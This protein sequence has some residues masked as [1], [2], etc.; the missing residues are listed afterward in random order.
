M[1]FID[2]H[3]QAHDAGM[4]AAAPAQGDTIRL[5]D[6]KQTYI[7]DD[8]PCGFAWVW[9]KGNTDWARWAKK[10][11]LASKSYP[12]GLSIWV[13]FFNQS[14]RKKEA[15]AQAYVAV[16]REHGIEAFAQSRMD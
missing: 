11:G 3:N 14:M 12:S 1:D 7:M 5:T 13:S 9:F 15:Y 4:K 6:G 16:L 8:Y 2:I 10:Q